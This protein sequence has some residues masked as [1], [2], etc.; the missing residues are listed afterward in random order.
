M[1]LNIDAIMQY[2]C[3]YRNRMDKM[4]TYW[5]LCLSDYEI[6]DTETLLKE[7]FYSTCLE[8]LETNMYIPLFQTDVVA[9]EEIYISQYYPWYVKTIKQLAEQTNYDLEFRK[10]IEDCLDS[11]GWCDFID[12][13]L[14]KD[15]IAWCKQNGIPYTEKKREISLSEAYRKGMQKIAQNK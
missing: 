10:F 3:F 6:Y 14:R 7:F 13:A 1:L 15:A 12:S 8:I 9:L 5:W 4:H 11:R 2:G